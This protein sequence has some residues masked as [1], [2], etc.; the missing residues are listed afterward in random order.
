MGAQQSQGEALMVVVQLLS[1][2]PVA[3]VI[4]P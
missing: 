4:V 2:V 1:P 3:S